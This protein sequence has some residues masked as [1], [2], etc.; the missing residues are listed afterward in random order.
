MTQSNSDKKKAK[1]R[2]QWFYLMSS[3]YFFKSTLSTSF[4]MI[5]PYNVLVNLFCLEYILFEMQLKHGMNTLWRIIIFPVTTYIFYPLF[6]MIHHV[7]QRLPQNFLPWWSQ[8]YIGFNNNVIRNDTLH[9]PINQRDL[10]QMRHNISKLAMNDQYSIWIHKLKRT[11][12]PKLIASSL[13][14]NHLLLMV[15]SPLIKTKS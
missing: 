13:S 11:G 14:V 12:T 9:A 4:V 8:P 1:F 2:S 7:S 10:Y 6:Y 15:A 5:L 3:M